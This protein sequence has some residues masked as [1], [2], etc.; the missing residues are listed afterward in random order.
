MRHVTESPGGCPRKGRTGFD[1][2][3]KHGGAL[4]PFR[5]T[6]PLPQGTA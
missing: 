3:E 4:R 5:D 2:I 6:R 1:G